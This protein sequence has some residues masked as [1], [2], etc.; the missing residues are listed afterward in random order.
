VCG[1][2]TTADESAAKEWHEE[3]LKYVLRGCLSENI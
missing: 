2:E 1:E 3:K